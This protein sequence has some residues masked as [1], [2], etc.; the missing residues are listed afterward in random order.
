MPAPVTVIAPASTA[1]P[2]DRRTARFRIPWVPRR[3]WN[4]GAVAHSGLVGLARLGSARRG[5]TRGPDGDGECR[6]G[7][8]DG[9]WKDDGGEGR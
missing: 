6:F 7:S 5:G 4:V 3:W 2:Q 9:G 1:G 8:G